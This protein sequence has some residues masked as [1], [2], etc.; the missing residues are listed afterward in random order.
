MKAIEIGKT[1]DDALYRFLEWRYCNF[2]RR[3][4]ELSYMKKS[5]IADILNVKKNNKNT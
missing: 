2:S 4:K 3:W 5:K 1:K